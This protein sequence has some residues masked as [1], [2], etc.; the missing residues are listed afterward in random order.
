LREG[1]R[2]VYEFGEKCES[3]LLPDTGGRRRKPGGA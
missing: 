3:E 1:G 2:V